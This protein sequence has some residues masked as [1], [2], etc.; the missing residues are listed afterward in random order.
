MGLV[1]LTIGLAAASAAVQVPHHEQAQA[2]AA[3]IQREA[4]PPAQATPR[5][6]RLPVV[7]LVQGIER[8]AVTYPRILP[9]AVSDDAVRLPTVGLWQASTLKARDA[10]AGLR[11]HF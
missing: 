2:P 6:D 8:K 11:W 10:S 5:V 3:G 7:M 9:L 4:P 1:S